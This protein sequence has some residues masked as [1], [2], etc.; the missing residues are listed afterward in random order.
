MDRP[1]WIRRLLP[2]KEKGKSK[3][4]T[5]TQYADTT[6][7]LL[8]TSWSWTRV[9]SGVT[10]PTTVVTPRPGIMSTT[11]TLWDPNRCC[12]TPQCSFYHQRIRE[13]ATVFFLSQPFTLQYILY[14]VLDVAQGSTRCSL[15][16]ESALLWFFHH[17]SHQLE[18][19][20]T[21]RRRSGR[22]GQLSER[23]SQLFRLRVH[24]RVYC[25]NGP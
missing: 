10:N 16:S 3:G 9:A 2:G 7:Q 20:S 23:N 8:L 21:G 17:G 14:V 1:N 22:G 18:Q 6:S 24:R 13:C 12:L 15:G 19:H 25:G 11:T 5:Y 4:Y